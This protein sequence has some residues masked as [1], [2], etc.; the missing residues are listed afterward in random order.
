MGGPQA[1]SCSC[2]PGQPCVRRGAVYQF[3]PLQ[4]FYGSVW[5]VCYVPVPVCTQ[6]EVRG[7]G[8][9]GV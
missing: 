5:S 9:D 1:R 8:V 3:L 7:A 6:V 2:W 4:Y